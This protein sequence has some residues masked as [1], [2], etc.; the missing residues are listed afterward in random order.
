MLLTVLSK[1]YIM[2]L[3]YAIIIPNMLMML[4]LALM[5]LITGRNEV[6]AKVIFSQACVILSTVGYLPGPGGVSEIL[7]GV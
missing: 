4:I 1:A 6:L 7:G 3:L 5:V 2:A